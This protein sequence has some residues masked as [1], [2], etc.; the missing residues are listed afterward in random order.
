[1]KKRGSN[2]F[3]NI[4]LFFLCLKIMF[5]SAGF[6]CFVFFVIEISTAFIPF[7]TLYATKTITNM[8][9]YESNLT[10][11][12]LLLPLLVF[13]IATSYSNIID[14]VRN[15]F[16]ESIQEKTAFKTQLELL[17]AV[18]NY[19]D[20]EIFEFSNFYNQLREAESGA[21]ARMISILHLSISMIKGIIGL[22][23]SAYLFV[24]IQWWIGVITL[25]SI[26]PTTYCGFWA[27][28]RRVNLFKNQSDTTRRMTYLK[29]ILVSRDAAKEIRLFRIQDFILNKYK[30]I[31]KTEHNRNNQLRRTNTLVGVISN[32]LCSSIIAFAIIFFIV[33]CL[34]GGEITIGDIIMY[35]GLIPQLA[36]SFRSVVNSYVY[37]SDNV[38]YISF[39]VDFIHKSREDNIRHYSNQIVEKNFSVSLDNVSFRYPA[40]TAYAINNISIKID[41]PGLY[42][43]V[44]KNGAGKSTI[45]KLLLRMIKPS[46]GKILINNKDINNYEYDELRKKQSGV[47][48]DFVQLSFKVSENIWF[49]NIDN[50]LDKDKMRKMSEMVC[51][52]KDIMKLNNNYDSFLGKE[53]KEGQ[54]LSRGQW[55]K[56]AWARALYSDKEMMIFDEPTSAID[57]ETES[58]IYEIIK[59]LS[60]NKIIILISHRLSSVINSTRIFVLDNGSLI[61]EGT[62]KELIIRNGIYKELFERQASGYIDE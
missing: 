54:E 7:I 6:L 33:D 24:S 4:R 31:F 17:K 41:G 2:F 20:A 34:E 35:I 55:Q 10:M 3:S 23:T 37:M 8:F 46:G 25:V 38:H 40:S 48:Q 30:E 28:R 58:K 1:M 45:V 14:P 62:H 52:H 51:L 29:N 60:K 21:G 22:V 53:F 16:S 42:S 36:I 39:Y 49:G 11:T 43:I 44:G 18:N 5:A 26:I 9:S 57:P 56:I 59:E 12:K 32:F 61:E 50:E 19:K 15:Y 13:V 47:F 27:S